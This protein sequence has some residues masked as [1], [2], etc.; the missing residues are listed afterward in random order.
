M[1]KGRRGG[2]EEGRRGGGEKGKR[3]GGEE[4]RRGEGEEGGGEE[5]RRGEGE[6]GGGEEGRKRGEKKGE[7]RRMGRREISVDEERIERGSGETR[8]GEWRW[9]GEEGEKGGER[10]IEKGYVTSVVFPNP[11]TATTYTHLIAG[12][13]RVWIK[14]S[15]STQSRQRLCPITPHT[16]PFFPPFFPFLPFLPCGGVKQHVSGN[17]AAAVKFKKHSLTQ[18]GRL[19]QLIDSHTLTDFKSWEI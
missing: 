4:G 1:E 5:G 19:S 7:R 2:G 18:A 14:H 11:N 15:H 9:K 17:T 10:H 16:L 12:Q 3:G 13:Q 6:E 8:R